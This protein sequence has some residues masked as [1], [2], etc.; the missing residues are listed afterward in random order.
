MWHSDWY[1]QH[2]LENMALNWT[3]MAWLP[4]QVDENDLVDQK[5]YRAGQTEMS[6]LK[7]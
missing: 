4:Y 1:S 7:A 6:A 2:E 3:D 5:H